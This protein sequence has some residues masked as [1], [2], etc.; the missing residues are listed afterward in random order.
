MALSNA[1]RQRRYRER[2]QVEQP[3]R[4]YETRQTKGRKSRPQRWREA[5]DQLRALQEEYESWLENCRTDCET[6]PR[7]RCLKP[8]AHSISMSSMWT[9]LGALGVTERKATVHEFIGEDDLQTFEGWLRYQ[10]VDAAMTTPEELVS[11]RRLF[12]DARERRAT[13]PKVG[14]MKLQAVPGEHRYAVAVREG[15]DLWLTLW[16]RRSRKGEFFIMLPRS[17]RDWDAHTSY[18]LDGT[19]HMKGFGHT[20]LPPQKRQPLTGTLR[21][22]EHLTVYSGYAPKSVGA[23]C[24]PAAFS[25]VVEVAPGVLGPSHGQVSVDLVEPGHERMG[26]PLTQI[27][28]RQV[29]RN[30]LPWVVITVGASG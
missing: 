13:S 1:E 4:R 2:R 15:S 9:C 29:F 16:V 21:G 5:L 12:E 18:H 10:A 20:L 23:I 8:P 6:N 27:V 14:L 11:W 3:I 28:T 17:N 26:V 30:I 22:S 19:L 24:D 7:Q 25:G